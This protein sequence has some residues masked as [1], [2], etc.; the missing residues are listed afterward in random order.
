MFTL[1]QLCRWVQLYVLSLTQVMARAR[2]HRLER[3]DTSGDLDSPAFKDIA[4]N[5]DEDMVPIPSPARGRGRGGRGRG[6]RGRGRGQFATAKYVKLLNKKELWMFQSGHLV[7]AWPQH[8]MHVPMGVIKVIV[9][10]FEINCNR[11]MQQF[12]FIRAVRKP[13]SYLQFCQI[14]AEGVK[15][16]QLYSC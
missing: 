2:L 4:M 8:V 7:I 5:S 12:L 6:G 11:F 14:P 10:W 15:T 9:I 3:G 1:S 13:I 16:A